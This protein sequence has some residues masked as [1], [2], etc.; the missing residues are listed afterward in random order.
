MHDQYLEASGLVRFTRTFIAWIS[1]GVAAF[2]NLALAQAANQTLAGA[3][4]QVTTPITSSSISGTVTASDG[5][6]IQGAHVRLSKA[7]SSAVLRQMNSG[8]MGEF[9]FSDLQPGTYVVKISG[10]G[11][12]SFVSQPVMLRSETPILMPDI[13]LGVAAASTSVVVMDKEAAS[14]QQVEIAEQQRVFKV[15]PNFYS[16]YD[17]DAPSMLAKQKYRLAARTL[18]DPV[19]FFTTGAI[20]GLEQYRNVFPSFG[21]GIEGYGKRYGA[22]YATEASG[23]LFTRAV[24]PSLFHTDPRYFIKGK[25]GT[26]ARA[27]HAIA[28]TFVT[29]ADNGSQRINFPEI[30][31]DFSSAALSNAYFPPQERGASLV[32]INGFAGLGGNMLDNLIR[33]FVLNRLTTHARH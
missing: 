12:T 7:G 26:K 6:V 33:E 1:L 32:L 18:V 14:I 9:K 31:G 3:Q 2:S 15:F 29:R 11:M 19:T 10:D 22:A 5:A 21:G 24:F 23:E 27:F 28:S 16:S 17:W 20:A 4:D 13:T 25:G 8:A 30:L